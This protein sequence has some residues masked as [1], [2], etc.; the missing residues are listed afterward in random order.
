MADIGVER[1]LIASSL[2]GVLAQRLVRC[3]CPHC[4]EE[5][6]PISEFLGYQPA[7][8]DFP[9]YAGKGCPR[10]AHTGYSGRVGLYEILVI[11]EDLS[12]GISQG[13]DLDGLRKIAERKGF[14]N[15]YADGLDKVR[16]GITTYSEVVR[17][18]R[19]ENGSLGNGSL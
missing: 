3:I 7:G 15:M 5:R 12:R 16:E 4:K 6:G 8:G 13:T 10:C 19:G 9:L 14:Q 2:R 1:F 17:V 18:S 11:D